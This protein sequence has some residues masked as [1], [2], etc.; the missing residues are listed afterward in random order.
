VLSL[1]GVGDDTV[2][3]HLE[4][5]GAGLI[6]VQVDITFCLIC[7]RLAIAVLVVRNMEQGAATFC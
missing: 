4:A 7:V 5:S 6:W 3:L 1:E 2:R